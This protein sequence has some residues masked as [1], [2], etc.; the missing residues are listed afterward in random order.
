MT[1]NANLRPVGF[2]TEHTECDRCGKPELRGTVVMANEDGEI[3][4]YYGT[5]CASKELGSKITRAD[6]L[7]NEA[8]RRSEVL[9][10]LQLASR[11]TGAQRAMYLDGA[12]R[13]GLVRADEIRYAAKLA[14]A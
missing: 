12:R 9:R 8:A 5:T 14:A 3:V 6:A 11:A 4:A 10:E 1:T 13:S 2:T 7:G